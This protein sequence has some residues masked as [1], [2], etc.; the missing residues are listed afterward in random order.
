MRYADELWERAYEEARN[1]GHPDDVARDMA[2][3]ALED[4]AGEYDDQARDREMMQ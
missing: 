2:D 4:R 3:Q 1:E